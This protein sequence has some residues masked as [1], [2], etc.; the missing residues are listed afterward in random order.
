MSSHVFLGARLGSQFFVFPNFAQVFDLA[1][2]VGNQ[3]GEVA[4]DFQVREGIGFIEV[5]QSDDQIL[6][7]QQLHPLLGEV[8][9]VVLPTFGEGQ[10]F[11]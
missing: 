2:P 9:K 5:Q 10:V 3:L 1:V 6:F 4:V 8:F 7:K 11:V